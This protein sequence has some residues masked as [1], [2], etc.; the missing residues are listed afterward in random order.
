MRP[1]EGKGRKEGGRD[2]KGRANS[3]DLNRRVTNTM[4][5]ITQ[6]ALVC[7]AMFA[8]QLQIH[9]IRQAMDIQCAM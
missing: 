6:I 7:V 8:A 9:L 4:S 3:V 1:G 5:G 2:E